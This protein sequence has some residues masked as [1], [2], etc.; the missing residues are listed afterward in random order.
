MLPYTFKKTS[1]LIKRTFHK[2][3][4]LQIALIT[5]LWFIAQEISLLTRM[6]IPGGVIGLVLVLALLYFDLLSI[7]SLALGAE[8]FLAEMLLFFIPAVPAVLNHQE[9]FGWTGLKILAIIIVGTMIVIIGTAIV[10]DFSFYKLEKQSQPENK[11]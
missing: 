10:V 8:W 6:P 4:I 1:I 5:V 9:F 11:Q 3:R 7:R 2:S